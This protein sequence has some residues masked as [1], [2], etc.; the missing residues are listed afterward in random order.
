[1]SKSVTL[2]IGERLA[3]IKLFD[4]FKGSVSELAVI[5]DDVKKLV[6]TEEQWTA[7]GRTVT[8]TDQGENWR[9]DEKEENQLAME[10]GAESA[11]YLLKSIKDKSDKNEVTI[12]DVALISL[13]KKLS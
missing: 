6:I 10:F 4:A 9:W 3:A 1:M 5:L 7:A 12:A 2:S 8:K 13:N 11:A